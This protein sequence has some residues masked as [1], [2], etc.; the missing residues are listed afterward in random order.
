MKRRNA[1][2]A[3][4][5]RTPSSAGQETEVARLTLERDYA[6]EQQ[7]ATSEVLRALSNS[8]TDITSTLGSIAE[9]VASLLNVTDVDFMRIDSYVITAIEKHGSSLHLPLDAE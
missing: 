6:I 1:P 8:P 3:V 5:R 4:R 7:R 2:K 9:S